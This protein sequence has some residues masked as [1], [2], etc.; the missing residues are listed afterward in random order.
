M[1]RGCVV[2]FQ[3][4]TSQRLHTNHKAS[5]RRLCLYIGIMAFRVVILYVV[6]NMVEDFIIKPST[7]S[8][9]WYDQFC[10]GKSFDFS[11]H[12]VLYF[13]QYLPIALLEVIHSFEFPFWKYS[14]SKYTLVPVLLIGGTLYLYLITLWSA[15]KTA[16]YFHTPVEVIIGMIISMFVQLPLCYLQCS[17]NWGYLREVFFGYPR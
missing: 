10:Y 16:A 14:S 4:L 2:L 5:F 3:L 17:T 13:A 12:Y 11:D 7:E 8:S 9:C 15:Y 1:G 6:F